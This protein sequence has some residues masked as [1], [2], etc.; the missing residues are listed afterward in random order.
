MYLIK[1][2]QFVQKLFPNFIWKVPT[3]EKQ[4]FLT[5]DDGPTSDLTPWILEQLEA[6]NAKATFFCVGEQIEQHPENF[7]AIT[8]AGHAIGNHTYSHP[9][10][11]G[12]DNI[13][14]F[15]DVRHCAQLVQSDLFRPPYGRLTPK[16]V[17][18]LERHYKIIMWDVMSGDFDTKLSE[19]DCLKNVID[20]A[21]KGSIVVL[22]DN[23]KSKARIKYVLPKIL[24]HFAAKGYQFNDIASALSANK[25]NNASDTDE[26]HQAIAA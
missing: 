26:Q 19:E 7:K 9:N 12:A 6:Y 25:G 8:E 18:F 16:Q 21:K 13:R 23:E 15:H 11:W 4:L 20:N 14:Y 24:E 1:T 2:P 22:H 3:T 10:G 17:Q 5:F